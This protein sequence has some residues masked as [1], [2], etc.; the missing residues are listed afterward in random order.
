[1]RSPAEQ[2]TTL[3]ESVI[4]RCPVTGQNVQAWIAQE[5]P[6]GGNNDFVSVECGACRRPHFVNPTTG[7]VLGTDSSPRS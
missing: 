1:M 3:M 2:R 7:R 5:I 4:F 6:K